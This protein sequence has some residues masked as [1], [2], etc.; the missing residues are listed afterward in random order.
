MSKISSK[1]KLKKAQAKDR[2]SLELEKI[3]SKNGRLEIGT[4]GYT[5]WDRFKIIKLFVRDLIESNFDL[6]SLDQR[7]YI[8]D[9][10]AGYTFSSTSRITLRRSVGSAYIS[11]SF[12][13]D[14]HSTCKLVV[15]CADIVNLRSIF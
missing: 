10:C 4:A 11:I 6:N 14:K 12:Q 7:G 15:T 3:G 1:R 13:Y 5:E 9:H 2:L 8:I